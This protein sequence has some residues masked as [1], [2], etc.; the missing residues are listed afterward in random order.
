MQIKNKQENKS[1]AFPLFFLCLFFFFC[2]PFLPSFLPFSSWLVSLL[3]LF[4]FLLDVPGALSLRQD[5][6]AP[7]LPHSGTKV[8][9]GPDLPRVVRAGTCTSPPLL[10][11][12]SRPDGQHRRA[13]R[14]P[15]Q[16]SARTQSSRR[17]CPRAPPSPAVRPPARRPIGWERVG[18]GPRPAR[19]RGPRPLP[20]SSA[21]AVGAEQLAERSGSQVGSFSGSPRGVWRGVFSGAAGPRT[22]PRP[23]CG[24]RPHPAPS[25]RV[26][27]AAGRGLRAG[28]LGPEEMPEPPRPVWGEQVTHPGEGGG[29]GSSG[30][31]LGRTSSS[32]CGVQG[33]PPLAFTRG[34]TASRGLEGRSGGRRAGRGR[35]PPSPV[36][37]RGRW[38]PGCWGGWG[39]GSRPGAARLAASGR[40]GAAGR[41]PSVC[42][43]MG[44]LW[45]EQKNFT[46]A[47]RLPLRGPRRQPVYRPEMQRCFL[48]F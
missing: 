46:R 38:D 22:G 41:S 1:V 21:L 14:L 3:P 43:R 25:C 44:G 8:S 2:L 26:F 7:G 16:S 13:P 47:R 36:G 39:G 34:K 24:C 6:G 12:V 30:R 4:L 35:R 27:L 19:P 23:P 42:A 45:A 40:G 18:A 48:I 33:Q 29:C 11:V 37:R 20:S 17:G 15:R 10:T 9:F 32:A 5:G 31:D 28:S